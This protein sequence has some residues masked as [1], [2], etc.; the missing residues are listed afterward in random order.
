MKRDP[1]FYEL[2]KELPEC[3]FQL[4]GRPEADAK[5]Y[6]LEAIEYKASAVRLDGVF[7]PLQPDKDPA[8]IWEAQFYPSDKVYANLLTKI[9]RFLEHGDP[10]QDFIAVVIYPNRAIEQANLV[11]YRFLLNSEQL[12]R[13]YLDELPPASPD[14][15]GLGILELISAKPEASLA[16]ARELIPRIRSARR[17]KRFEEMLLQFIETVIV[18][19]FPNWSREEIEKMLQ[20]TDVRQTRVFQEALEEGMEK[21][22]EKGLEKGMEKGIETVA[23]RL[24]EMGRPVSE[25][26]EATGLSAAQIRKLKK[27][28][29]KS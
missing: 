3:F 24:L 17:S 20:V 9:G 14:Q 26:A 13:V 19:Q 28:G 7:R 6:E 5:R 21:G 29:G 18:H 23:R 11:P 2:F 16:K 4:V 25:I 22:I 8:F 12:R 15:F 10:T 27:K 1:L